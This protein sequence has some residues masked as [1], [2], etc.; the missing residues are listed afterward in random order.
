MNPAATSRDSPL[1]LAV[2]VPT[3]QEAQML[4]ALLASLQEQTMPAER[5]VV[6]DGGSTDGTAEIAARVGAQL[7]LCPQR[8]R[9][10]QIAYA[11]EHCCEDVILIAHADM[12]FPP[13]ALQR[14][15]QHL[16]THPACAGGCLGHRFDRDSLPYRLIAWADQ[17]RARRGLAY[18]D[19]AQ[20][21]RR[22]VLPRIGGFPPWPLFED[23][24]LSLRLQQAGPV[25]Y[26]DVPVTVSVRR[27]QRRGLLGTLWHNWRLR[28]RFW[29]HGEAALTDLYRQYYGDTANK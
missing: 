28:R 14:L 5:I 23:V 25:V 7:I 10:C 29:R 24:A 17:R 2:I 21:F 4:P 8:G 20:F 1:T 18:G 11:L 15:R 22:N 27:F 12:L 19:Q 26:L 13:I 16:Q 3:W 6:A 9:G